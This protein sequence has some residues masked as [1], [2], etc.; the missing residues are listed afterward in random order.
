MADSKNI[1]VKLNGKVDKNELV[2]VWAQF[3]LYA[4]YS[5]FKDLYNKTL[6]PV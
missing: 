1:Y 5:D 4:V 6:I 2:K 3:K